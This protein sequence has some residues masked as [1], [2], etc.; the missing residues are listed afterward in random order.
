MKIEGTQP[1]IL[2]QHDFGAQNNAGAD[3][4]GRKVTTNNTTN[5]TTN[6]N[7]LENSEQNDTA[8]ISDRSISKQA[9]VP[10]KMSEVKSLHNLSTSKYLKDAVDFTYYLKNNNAKVHGFNSVNFHINEKASSCVLSFFVDKDNHSALDGLI[11]NIRKNPEKH[12]EKMFIRR[13][14]N[15][16]VPSMHQRLQP[17]DSHTHKKIDFTD[18]NAEDFKSMVTEL[19]QMGNIP[20]KEA[21]SFVDLM[22][23]FAQH[24]DEPGL[25]YDDGSYAEKGGSSDLKDHQGNSEKTLEHVRNGPYQFKTNPN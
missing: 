11:E 21:A 25:Q 5:N 7:N 23:F 9:Q 24:P 10:I 14:D 22:H 4:N 3:K 15:D 16:H 2:S 6:K 17:T 13:S 8:S 18:M 12:K 19:F 1:P 20:E